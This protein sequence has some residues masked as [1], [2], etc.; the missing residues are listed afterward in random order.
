MWPR[1]QQRV[2]SNFTLYQDKENRDA[3]FRSKISKVQGARQ[4]DPFF[5]L[6][7]NLAVPQEHRRCRS[8]SNAFEDEE[9]TTLKVHEHFV[10][11]VQRR[12]VR[13]VSKE[14]A[15]GFMYL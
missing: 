2:H 9:R 4:R 6:S 8:T 13:E 11:S 5:G 7:T 1:Q 12:S 3:V 10:S 14:I 15:F